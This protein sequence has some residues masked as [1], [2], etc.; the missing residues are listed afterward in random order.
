M[1]TL[2]KLDWQTVNVDTM[3]PALKRAYDKYLGEME[4]AKAARTT[5]EAEAT[6][7]L[8]K[9]KA[10]PA[11]MEPRFGYNWGRL[12]IAY[13]EPSKAKSAGGGD[14]FSFK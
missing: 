7:I 12:A 5:F 10:I 1:P 13:A 6:A 4:K 9:A 3:P 2:P 8:H 11:G 14:L